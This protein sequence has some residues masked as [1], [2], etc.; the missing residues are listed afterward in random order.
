MWPHP[1]IDEGHGA[2]MKVVDVAEFYAE[3]GGGVKTYLDQKLRAG[4]AAGHE[5]VVLAPGPEDAEESRHGGRVIWVKS[6]KVP[7]DPR[8]HLFI[9]RR[10][11]HSVLDR[12]RPN[13]VEG[14]SVYGGGWFAGLWPGRAVRSLVFHQDPVAALGHPMLDRFISA[15]T[16]D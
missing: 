15:S 8:Y 3:K 11:V 10:A 6:P 5:V 16:I 9:D 12:E 7:G 2:A 13:V 4:S 1:R 14:S